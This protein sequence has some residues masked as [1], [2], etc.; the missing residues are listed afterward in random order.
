MRSLNNF[1]AIGVCACVVFVGS[2]LR[3]FAQTKSDGWTIIKTPEKAKVVD[4]GEAARLEQLRL[5]LSHSTGA[6]S[7]FGVN[8]VKASPS[9]SA[10]LAAKSPVSR[11][12]VSGETVVQKE[13]APAIDKKP[14]AQNG[15]FRGFG[16]V[17]PVLAVITPF[18]GTGTI[19]T[20]LGG[21]SGKNGP[22]LGVLKPDQ[23]TFDQVGNGGLNVSDSKVL[24]A[25]SGKPVLEGGDGNSQLSALNDN[26]DLLDSVM[27]SGGGKDGG[28]QKSIT[29]GDSGDGLPSASPSVPPVAT[30]KDTSGGILSPD[31]TNQSGSDPD[32]LE[33][34][35][36]QGG[37]G[38]NPSLVP[39]PS[40]V[41][42]PSPVVESSV[43][44]DKIYNVV[45]GRL[46]DYG[47][48]RRSDE[49]KVGFYPKAPEEKSAQN[50][51]LSAEGGDLPAEKA[52]TW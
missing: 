3:G 24:Q 17:R 29:G 26:G 18:M 32:K 40:P 34:V 4:R 50:I 22:G 41:A 23:K 12:V 16:G 47:S 37:K 13:V 43:V 15:G 49:P 6:S 38:L 25:V 42:S 14:F 28:E 39:S 36:D 35:K 45:G 33:Q 11:S 31:G 21:L 48:F 1:C 5:A 7:G 9:P 27:Q 44:K 30:N 2:G 46:P 52:P 51:F 20:A 10:G 8:V 19:E